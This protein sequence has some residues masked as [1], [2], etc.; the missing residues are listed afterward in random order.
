MVIIGFCGTVFFKL[1]IA[2][3]FSPKF[4]HKFPMLGTG[5]SK[6]IASVPFEKFAYK[7]ELSQTSKHPQTSP[8]HCAQPPQVII[9]NG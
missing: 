1:F 5:K 9:F 4:A 6:E 3:L 2:W 8:P 7:L